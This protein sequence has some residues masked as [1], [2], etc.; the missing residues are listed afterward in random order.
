[1]PRGPRAV[2]DLATEQE[3]ADAVLTFTYPDRLLT[4]QPLTDL[5]SI[6]IYRVVNPAP[7]LT[8]ARPA[9]SSAGPRTD[10]APAA[11]ARRA[12]TAARAAEESFRTEAQRIAVLPLAALARATRGA[13]I[14]YRDPLPPIFARPPE[15]TS[16]AYAVVSVRRNGERSPL[17]NITVLAPAVPPGAPVILAVTPEEGRICLEWLAPET[18]LFGRKPVAVGGYFVYRRA[19]PEE[20]YETPVNPA[21]VPGTD[22]VDTTAPSGAKLAY[23]V[24][25]TLPLKPKVEGPPAEEAAVDFR[26]VFAPPAPARLDALSEKA[27]VRLVWDP[28]ASPDLAGYALFR[29]EGSAAPVRLNKELVKDAFAADETAQSGHSYRYTV[30]AVDAAGNVS[31]PS[32]EAVAEPF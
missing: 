24:R 1:M 23:T 26:D 2:S 10:E 14:V 19:L 6:E 17:S 32:P 12:A 4:G 31:E 5:E 18:N 3:A 28:V 21:P 13:T 20:E 7:A 29:A 8:A 25:A 11:A 16:L 9:A 22:Y 30:R 15:P 27:L